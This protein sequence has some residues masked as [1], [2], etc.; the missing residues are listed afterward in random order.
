MDWLNSIDI[1]LFR[2]INNSGYEQIDLLIILIS[3]KWIWIPLYLYLLYLLYKRYA[4]KFI[5]IL[6]SLGVLI[7]LAWCYSWLLSMWKEQ[8]IENIEAVFS[9]HF[10]RLLQR[11]NNITLIYNSS[12]FFHYTNKQRHYCLMLIIASQYY[13]H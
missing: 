12:T 11:A 2:L 1:Q 5:W 6:I 10:Y 13:L 4:S 7:F 9:Y 8:S 3:S